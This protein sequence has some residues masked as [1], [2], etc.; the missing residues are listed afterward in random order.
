MSSSASHKPGTDGPI[1]MVMIP[2]EAGRIDLGVT[3]GGSPIAKG[4][5]VGGAPLAQAAAPV[6]TTPPAQSGNAPANP[7]AAT[8]GQAPVKGR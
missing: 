6:N 8:S 5:T 2:N 1:F 4:L 7:P 3:A